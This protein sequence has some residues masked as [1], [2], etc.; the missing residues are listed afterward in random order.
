[1]KRWIDRFRGP[2][3]ILPY[4]G[5]GTAERLSLCGRVLEDEGFRPAR[6]A[7]RAWRNLVEMYKRFES[8]EVPGA[9]V[10]ARFQGAEHLRSY[11][12]EGLF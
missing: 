8:D 2:Y 7:D 10:R 4:P 12:C 5:F 11:V 6:D 9:R 3:I 1:M